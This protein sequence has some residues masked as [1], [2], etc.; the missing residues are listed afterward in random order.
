MRIYL[1]LFL[2]SLGLLLLAG[3]GAGAP[4]L[5]TAETVHRLNASGAGLALDDPSLQPTPAEPAPVD[6]CVVC[7]TDRARLTDTADPEVPAESES[8][9]VG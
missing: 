7:H 6:E 3:C 9:G 5:V 4:A 2:T 1:S 8:S